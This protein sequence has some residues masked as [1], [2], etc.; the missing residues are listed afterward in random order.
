MMIAPSDTNTL[1]NMVN[2]LNPAKMT[3]PPDII[4]ATIS[5]HYHENARIMITDFLR[6]SSQRMV[7]Y[8]YSSGGARA[9]ILFRSENGKLFL[10]FKTADRGNRVY[11]LRKNLLYDV[12]ED[13]EDEIPEFDEHATEEDLLPPDIMSRSYSCA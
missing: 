10:V 2:T 3:L 13:H 9:H 5:S 1:E 11:Y 8:G 7:T 6:D 12:F 4:C